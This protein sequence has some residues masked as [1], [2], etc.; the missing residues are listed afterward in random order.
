MDKASATDAVDSV[1][2]PGP[3]KPNTVKIGIHSFPA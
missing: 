3:V 2:I 1:S